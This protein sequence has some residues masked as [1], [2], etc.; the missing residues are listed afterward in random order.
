MIRNNAKRI[1]R[2]V[3]EVLQLNR[4]DRQQPEVIVLGEFMHSLI[5][6]IV[7][8]ENIPPGGVAMQVPDGPAA[9]SSIAGT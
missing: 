4:R 7:Q 1:D 2:I 9:S 6:E 3:G 5:D 8:A